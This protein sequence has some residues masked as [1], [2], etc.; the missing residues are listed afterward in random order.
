MG[1]DLDIRETFSIRTTGDRYRVTGNVALLV[2]AICLDRGG[3][4]YD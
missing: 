1:R 4:V 3:F 2:R